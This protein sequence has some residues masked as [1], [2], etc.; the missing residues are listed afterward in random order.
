MWFTKKKL[1]VPETND[2]I[3]I[4]SI[5][6]WK[7]QWTSRYGEFSGHT[8]QEFEAFTSEREAN[9]FAES[10]RNAF[11]LIRHTSGNT[12]TVTKS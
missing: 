3:E 6:L 1:T 8:S 7:V 2:T 11:K 10:L 5:Q 9:D 12:V 4:E